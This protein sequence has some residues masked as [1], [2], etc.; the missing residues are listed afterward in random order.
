[1]RHMCVCV[2]C[3]RSSVSAL[4]VKRLGNRASRKQP[5]LSEWLNECYLFV[6]FPVMTGHSPSFPLYSSICY[7]FNV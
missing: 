7:V 2:V 5:V 3:V 6:F 4:F 1:M